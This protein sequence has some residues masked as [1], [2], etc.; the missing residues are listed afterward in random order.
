[1]KFKKLVLV[2]L[3]AAFAAFAYCAENTPRRA[4]FKG[5]ERGMGVGGWLTNYKRPQVLPDSEK[6][7][8]TVGDL[9][10]F[11]S[12][13]TEA[14]LKYIASLGCDH[15]RLG[16][17]QIVVEEKPYRYRE[18]AMG[19]IADF[20]A[21]AKKHKLN[22]VLNLHKA[23][24]N[25]CDISQNVSLLDDA[26]LQNRF[27]KMW[28]EMEKRFA[29]DGDVV[30]ELLNE[31][32]NV[33]PQKWNALAEKTVAAIREKNPTRKIIVGSTSWNSAYRLKDLKIFDD[34]NVIYT[35]HFYEPFVFTHQRG[36]LQ[37]KPLAYNRVMRYPSDI[38][39]YAEFA[40][41][42]GQKFPFSRFDKMDKRVLRAMLSPAIEF[43][44][45]N[46]DKILW[47]GEFGTIRHA[48][49]QSR[50][51]WLNDVVLIL[52]ENG[53]P[54]CVWN[55]L[56]TPND[57]NRFSLVDDDNRKILSPRLAKIIVGEVE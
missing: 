24:G 23:V 6:F 8:I 22:V 34:P 47:C 54:Y 45:K 51:N 1:M 36:V 48:P 53:I 9:E 16:F 20:V 44:K 56:S 13:I 29:N 17:D 33:P 55:Y 19:Q 40:E 21:W 30:F 52:K 27:V 11:R 3:C 7:R 50:E 57:G 41:F 35:F 39:P 25:Y 14:D 28:V 10:H 42:C 2:L 32:L 5:F 46:P 49:L 43:V 26:E 38:A 18:S 31:V 4:E 15:V 12:Y 37:A